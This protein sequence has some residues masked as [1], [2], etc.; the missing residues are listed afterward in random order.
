ML[1]VRKDNLLVDLQHLTL[2]SGFQ[3]NCTVYIV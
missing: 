1:A 2:L 3:D